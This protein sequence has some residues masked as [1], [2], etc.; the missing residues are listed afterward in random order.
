MKRWYVVCVAAVLGLATLTGCSSG[1]GD[2]FTQRQYTAQGSE[3]K[4]VVIDVRDRQIEIVPAGDG[5]LVLDYAESEKEGYAITLSDEGTLS[6][7]GRMDKGWLDYIGGK[8]P[9][10]YRT[11]RLA[12][13][14]DALS[15][16]TV[17]TTN[18]DI[19]LP[20]LAVGGEVSLAAN[21][22]DIR[23]EKLDVGQGLRLEAKNGSVQGTVVGGY[24]DFTISSTV[25]KGE[26]N[27]PEQAG[28]GSK[29]LEADVNNGNIELAFEK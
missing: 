23:L 27:L 8:A 9:E 18:G 13:P 19:T 15:S 26:S 3:V 1:E 4:A 16:L 29:T 21:N 17:S 5:Q 12:V 10:E 20:A 25:K 7:T 24:D 2:T 11:L 14:A 28:S 6:V 22:G